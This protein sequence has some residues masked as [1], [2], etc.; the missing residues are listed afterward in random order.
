M[1]RRLTD[2]KHIP[3]LVAFGRRFHARTAMA[4]IPFDDA[5][6][7]RLLKSSMVSLDSAVW[8]AMDTDGKFCGL[9]IGTI[10]PWP[11]CEGSYATDLVFA[12]DRYGA[13][14]YRAFEQWAWKSKVNA[15][16]VGVSSGMPQA[17]AF[18]QA[19]GMRNTGG[20]YLQTAPV[21]AEV[22]A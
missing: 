17:D 13:E 2:V 19:M 5:R 18:Y 12:A 10:V 1:I 11:W 3:R 22:A 7:E 15:I 9:L 8:G 14:L 21:G 16:Q 4:A 20:M 6:A